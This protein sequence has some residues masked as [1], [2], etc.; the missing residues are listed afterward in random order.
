ML[1][2]ILMRDE[3]RNPV[4]GVPGIHYTFLSSLP[5]QYNSTSTRKTGMAATTSQPT[6]GLQA[7]APLYQHEGL[8]SGVIQQHLRA[9]INTGEYS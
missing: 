8:F 2:S 9:C 4:G 7:C 6:A 5:A 1:H 3:G